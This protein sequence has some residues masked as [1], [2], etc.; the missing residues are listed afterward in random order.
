MSNHSLR[1]WSLKQDMNIH[2]QLGQMP[3]REMILTYADAALSM[4][5]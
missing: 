5:G 3:V 1:A 4:L 2:E